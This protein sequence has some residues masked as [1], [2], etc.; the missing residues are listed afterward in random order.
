MDGESEGQL[1][2]MTAWSRVKWGL[3]GPLTLSLAL[4][5]ARYAGGVWGRLTAACFTVSGLGYTAGMAAPAVI[6]WRVLFLGIALGM[7]AQLVTLP[8]PKAERH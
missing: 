3:L 6:E 7:V 4:V 1:Q 5:N 8:N 2:A